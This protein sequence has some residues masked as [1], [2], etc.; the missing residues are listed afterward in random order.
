MEAAVHPARRYKVN[1]LERGLLILKTIRTAE[2]P[3]RTHEIVPRPVLQ[4]ATVSRL[5][6][7]LTDLDYLRRIDQGSYVLGQASSRTGRAML[8]GLRLEQYAPCFRKLV[9]ALLGQVCLAIRVNDRLV[10]VFQWAATSSVLLSSGVDPATDDPLMQECF[11]FFHDATAPAAATGLPG[12]AHQLAQT[13]WCHRWQTQRGL[14]IACTT[15][16]SN[17]VVEGALALHLP[18]D[19]APSAQQ[20]AEIGGV[21]LQAAAAIANETP[22]Q[23]VETSWR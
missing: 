7:T 12:I 3:M 9:S 19:Q 10:P 5:V 20:L 15:L 14:L 18:L 22:E 4:N 17:P 2:G 16:P 23:A 21:L 11:Q 8:E 6:H 13:G 1:S